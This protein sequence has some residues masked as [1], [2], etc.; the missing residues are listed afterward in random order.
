MYTLNDFIN[1]ET[2]SEF[3]LQ[4][5]CSFAIMA[6]LN[7]LSKKGLVDIILINILS[8]NICLRLSEGVFSWVDGAPM[9]FNGWVNPPQ[10]GEKKNCVQ[11][12]VSVGWVDTTCDT[13]LPFICKTIRPGKASRVK[14]FPFTLIFAGDAPIR[15]F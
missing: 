7:S 11:L 15:T 5:V 8:C 1:V 4:L 6:Y 2:L 3:E 14:P 13:N 10:M 9:S 12:D